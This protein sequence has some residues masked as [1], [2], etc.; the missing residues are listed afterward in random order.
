MSADLLATDPVTAA[1][2]LL[3]ARLFGREVSAVILEV[4]AYGGPPDG[5]WPDPA[6]HSYRGPRVRNTVMFGPAGPLYAY[7]S[8]GI[9]VCANV[10]TGYDGVPSAVL[11]PRGGGRRRCR[12]RPC[13]PRRVLARSDWLAVLATCAPR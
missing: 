10:V 2:R 12:R 4:E 5:P 7:L 11:H 6:S 3:G 1:Q 13:S 9:H 8:H